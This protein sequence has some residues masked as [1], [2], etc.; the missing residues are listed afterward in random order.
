MRVSRQ[1]TESA[2]S[3]S[4]KVSSFSLLPV[5]GNGSGRLFA[6]LRGGLV[7]AMSTSG[8]RS[9]DEDLSYSAGG[10]PTTSLSSSGDSCAFRFRL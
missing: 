5:V 10:V 2:S 4:S 6:G 9:A 8:G 7:T 1:S 3:S